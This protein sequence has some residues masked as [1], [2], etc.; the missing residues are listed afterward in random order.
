M[1]KVF[2]LVGL[3]CANC[4]GKIER[5]V[6]KLKEIDQVTVDF[7]STKMLLELETFTPEL[8]SKIEKIVQKVESHVV[9]EAV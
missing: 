9:L 6:G 2:K 4:A 7:M 1:K 3:G 5:K 8:Q